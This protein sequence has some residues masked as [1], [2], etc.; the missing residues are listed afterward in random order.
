MTCE[1]TWETCLEI[2]VS[3]DGILSGFVLHLEDSKLTST[4]EAITQQSIRQGT[5]EIARGKRFIVLIIAS[6]NPGHGIRICQLPNPVTAGLLSATR[7]IQPLDSLFLDDRSYT[8]PRPPGFVAFGNLIIGPKFYQSF[9]T[10]PG[11]RLHPAYD[12]L[13]HFDHRTL[14][15][16]GDEE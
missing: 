15:W 16:K 7:A 5:A 1:D 4:R 10:S 3:C 14:P 2:R 9:G 11:H 6:A 12:H 8:S 13:L